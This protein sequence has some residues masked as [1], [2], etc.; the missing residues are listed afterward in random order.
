MPS[1]GD[2]RVAAAARGGPGADMRAAA[3]TPW[4]SASVGRH[5]QAFDR[6]LLRLGSTW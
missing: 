3:H 5:T 4:A 1:A 2:T 6:T